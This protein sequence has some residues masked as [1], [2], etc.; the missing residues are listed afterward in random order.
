M[1]SIILVALLIALATLVGCKG[2][3]ESQP[4]E[5][6]MSSTEMDSTEKAK[7]KMQKSPDAMEDP[8]AAAQSP[9]SAEGA[10]AAQ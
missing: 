9:E 7:D 2:K 8:A 3:D 1:R 5:N 10:G 6:A 4:V